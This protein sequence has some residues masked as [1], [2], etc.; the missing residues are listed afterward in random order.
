MEENLSNEEIEERVAILKRYRKMLEEQRAKFREY[1]TV[2]EKQAQGIEEENEDVIAAHAELEHQ[3][4]TNISTLHKVTLPLEKLYK[5]S[6]P[7]EDAH[8]H[9]LKADL[10]ILR[11]EVLKQN[12]KNRELL[13][14][15]ITEVRNQIKRIQNPKFNPYANSRSVYSQNSA[16]ASIIDVEM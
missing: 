15:K 1:L 9:E 5:D 12:E 14:T 2:L 13:K 7:E 4:V 11:D 8:I 16:T 3:I 6:H 10:Q